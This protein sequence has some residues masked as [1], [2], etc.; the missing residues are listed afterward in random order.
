VTALDR[1]AEAVRIARGRGLKAV[2][3]D[4]FDYR[5]GTFDVVLFTRSLHHLEM[6]ARALDHARSL[7]EPRGLVIA[8]EFAIE[9]MD[10]D[11]ARWFFEL[12]SLLEAAAM[13]PPEESTELAA[14]NPLER[15]YALHAAEQPLHSGEDMLLAM[16]SR[17]EMIDHR[18]VPYLYRSICDRIEQSDR[19]IRVG[20][21]VLELESLR[22]SERTLR[23]VGLR[24]TAR[25]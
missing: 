22:I 20:Q 24:M 8:E 17:L 2:E 3:S 1:S 5:E 12:R 14:S 11:T 21:W 19:G 25:V 6:P 13:L 16:G 10:R 7:L 15:W 4:F 18:R 9:H 23:P